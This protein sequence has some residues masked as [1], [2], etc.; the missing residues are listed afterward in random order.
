MLDEIGMENG[1]SDR[2]KLKSKS[3]S[4]RSN[5]R[6][7]QT[8]RQNVQKRLVSKAKRDESLRRKSRYEE[9]SSDGKP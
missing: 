8:P 5:T 9:L 7:P 2:I 3:L 1:E 4:I 6:S